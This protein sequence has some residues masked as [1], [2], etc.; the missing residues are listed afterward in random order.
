MIPK[1]LVKF[2]YSLSNIFNS[3]KIFSHFEKDFIYSGEIGFD[4]SKI[5]E[6]F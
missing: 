6:S 3:N 5:R 2:I 1:I 4:C